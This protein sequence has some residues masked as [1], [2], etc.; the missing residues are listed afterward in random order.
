MIIFINHTLGNVNEKEACN[1]KNDHLDYYTLNDHTLGK[2][3]HNIDLKQDVPQLVIDQILKDVSQHKLLI[4]KNQGVIS[5]QRQVEI[6]QWFGQTEKQ[7]PSHKHNKSPHDHILRVSNDVQEGSIGIGRNGYGWHIDGSY[8]PKPNS[9]ALYH[10]IRCTSVGHTYFV[11]LA[12]VIENLDEQTR[13]FWWKLSWKSCRAG[14][15]VHPLIYPH[16]DTGQPTMVFN[17]Y[18]SFIKVHSQ[19][20]TKLSDLFILDYGTDQEKVY[21]EVETE[22]IAKSIAQELDKYRYVHQ[23]QPGD[24]LITDNLAVAHMASPGT[25]YDRT[26]V[27]LRV[28]HRVTVNGKYQPIDLRLIND[29]KSSK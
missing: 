14:T 6:G 24:L 16:P 22:A 8:Y 29:N 13:D 11:D 7:I 4:F 2:T 1:I 18:L 26:E 3:V 25:Q 5:S 10:I 15:L 12:I 21:S 28:M 23:W 20:S 9:H 17:L 19:K 27:G